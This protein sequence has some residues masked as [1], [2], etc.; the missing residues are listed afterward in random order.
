MFCH[1][2]RS[3]TEN[4]KKTK[5]K[6]RMQVALRW[7]WVSVASMWLSRAGKK[8]LVRAVSNK[9]KPCWWH[10]WKPSMS[11]YHRTVLKMLIAL[12]Y[13]LSLIRHCKCVERGQNMRA[14]RGPK[15]FFSSCPHSVGLM[16]LV[17]FS[18]HIAFLTQY[19]PCP[20]VTGDLCFCHVCVTTGIMS[21]VTFKFVWHL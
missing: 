16:S 13:F 6:N 9:C 2:T 4:K 3:G 15:C 5:T 19:D 7:W 18:P 20:W 17:H 12:L 14:G 11:S 21:T 8:Y 1:H 10:N